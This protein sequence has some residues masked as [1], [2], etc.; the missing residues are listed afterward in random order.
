MKVLVSIK[1]VYG[2]ERIY[3]ECDKSK[4]FAKLKGQTTLTSSDIRIIKDLG[5]T[6]EVKQEIKEL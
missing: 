3:P 4:L 6:V 5:Y 1:Q 2:N